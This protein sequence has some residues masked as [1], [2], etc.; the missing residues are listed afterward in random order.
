MLD[1]AGKRV[2]RNG[3]CAAGSLD[4]RL[5]SLHNAGPLQRGDLDDL[6]AELTGQFGNIDLVAVFLDDV[7]HVDRNDHRN[8]Q[9]RKLCGKVQV[10]FKIRTVDDVQNCVRPLVD[11]VVSCDDLLKR[12][13]GQR[14]NAGQVHDDHI[15]V[16]FQASLLLL[17]RDARPVADKLVRSGER[18]EQRRLAGVRI[19]CERN[20]DSVLFHLLLPQS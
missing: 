2:H 16:L 7:H 10:A 17:D 15:L 4:R 3:L 5:G 9:L 12:I 6:A 14:V 19:A 8:P 18:I 1:C 11:E 13:R 20:L